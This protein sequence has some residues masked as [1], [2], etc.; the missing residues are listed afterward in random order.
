M[1]VADLPVAAPDP[2]P[3]SV[4]DSHCHL[5]IT[6]EYSGLT[7]AEALTAAAAVG[8]TGIVQVGVDLASSERAVTL[9]QQ[10]SNVVAAVAV[11]P[12]EAPEVRQS[13]Q[14]DQQLARLAELA[15][16]PD[17]VAVGETGMDFY[18]TDESGRTDQE[19]SFR[20]HI[21]LA[22]ATNRTLVIHDRDAHDAVLRILASEDLPE[23]VVFHCFSGDAEMAR[24]CSEAGWFLSFPGVVTFRNAPELR[25]A[26]SVADPAQ[27]LVE[28]DA[29]FLTPAPQRGRPNASYLMPH[30]V[31]AMAHEI[32]MPLDELC[33][34]LRANTLRA[35][36]MPAGFTG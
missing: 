32:E 4:I 26:L 28:T 21:A 36:R 20:E 10:E 14:L 34:T 19:I 7:P 25:K 29:P 18:R 16:L 6:E 8:V 1:T 31:R 15:E 9:A 17:V 12:N 11:H 35:F 23:R 24:V 13:G 30:T 33:R 22:K 27:I 2:L 3:A 5:D